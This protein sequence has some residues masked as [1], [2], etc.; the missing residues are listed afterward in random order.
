MTGFQELEEVEVLPELEY[1][2]P[3]I[4]PAEA[5]LPVSESPPTGELTVIVNPPPPPEA[6]LMLSKEG[7]V[8]RQ[9]KRSCLEGFLPVLVPKLKETPKLQWNRTKIPAS[10]FRQVLGF[11]LWTHRTYRGESQVRLYY[12]AQEN[13]W[14]IVVAP[15]EVSTGLSTRELASHADRIAAFAHV[16]SD[17]WSCQG[18]IHH[19]CSIGAFQSGTDRNDEKMQNGLHITIGCLDDDVYA[20]H[21]RATFGGV[22]Y[23]VELGDWLE[24][25]EAPNTL[26]GKADTVEF[27]E[28]WT[29]RLVK[30]EY[31]QHRYNTPMGF[32][33]QTIYGAYWDDYY[34][35]Q[36]RNPWPAD[37]HG[38]SHEANKDTKVE[39]WVG[40]DRTLTPQEREEER[41][42]AE[43]Q[44]YL[45]DE[46]PG[47]MVCHAGVR[48]VG[49]GREY[50]ISSDR[51]KLPKHLREPSKSVAATYRKFLD[52][53]DI[54]KAERIT[55]RV[56]ETLRSEYG[57][58]ALNNRET[59]KS[60]KSTGFQLVVRQAIEAGL[61][62]DLCQVW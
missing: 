4:L 44:T 32:G 39:L 15:Q 21:G 46:P 58:F 5:V 6:E 37:R 50:E 14:D 26:L 2:K 51:K 23:T 47:S 1:A 7:I 19:H 60:L 13:L 33:G 56:L 20:I 43:L 24:G 38:R 11:F 42:L 28:V 30:V 29:T 3:E 12:N 62:L 40:R 41:E 55:N 52:A 53:E 22:E 18:T 45:K 54:A 34:S 36:N 10:L 35:Q 9:Q 59:T 49:A 27:P 31:A 25:Y 61:K 17:Q 8:V 57:K 48:G 16:A